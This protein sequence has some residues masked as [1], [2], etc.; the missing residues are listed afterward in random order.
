MAKETELNGLSFAKSYFSQNKDADERLGNELKDKVDRHAKLTSLL[1]YLH[2]ATHQP[3]REQLSEPY[4]HLQSVESYK[5]R[6]RQLCA[7]NEGEKIE[8]EDAITK[9]EQNKGFLTGSK[10]WL[11]R[12]PRYQRNYFYDS[13]G[14]TQCNIGDRDEELGTVRTVLANIDACGDATVNEV[15]RRLGLPLL[16]CISG[17][18]H[19]DFTYCDGEQLRHLTDMLQTFRPGAEDIFPDVPTFAKIY[20]IDH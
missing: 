10:I 15:P 8:F 19:Q 4:R 20:L 12:I 17:I 6:I 18:P 13:E 2:L 3:H 5:I 16:P 11:L 9:I 1:T 7:F 14:H